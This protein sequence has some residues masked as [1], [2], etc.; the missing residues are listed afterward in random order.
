[1]PQLLFTRILNQMFASPVNALLQTL[2]IH[3][4][5]QAAPIPDYVAMQ[6][7][8]VLLLVSFF[9]AVRSRLSV[10]A[11]GGLQ[12]VMEG[13]HSFVGGLGSDIIG[14]G[15]EPYRPYLVC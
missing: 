3:P 15:F 14:H 8:V 9:I 10:E 5:H 13:I 2:G 1:M 6:V 11:P 12:H 4:A 7:L